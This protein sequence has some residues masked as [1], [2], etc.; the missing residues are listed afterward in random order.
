MKI[1]ITGIDGMIGHKIAQSLSKEHT[2]IGSSRKNIKSEDLG[3]KD[4]ELITHDFLQELLLSQYP[5]V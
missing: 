5:V 2:I 3:I 4:C 1:F